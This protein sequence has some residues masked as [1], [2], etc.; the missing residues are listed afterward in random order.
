MTM[1]RK[2]IGTTKMINQT[3][4]NTTNIIDFI[5]KSLNTE[6]I[7]LGGSRRFGWDT[8][9]S[10]YDL[11][12]YTSDID[13]TVMVLNILGFQLKVVFN[14][15]TESYEEAPFRT[16]ELGKI[17]ISVTGSLGAWSYLR[18]NHVLV[19]NYLISNPRIVDFII[20]W[21]AELGTYL[22]GTYLVGHGKYTYRTLLKMAKISEEAQE[23]QL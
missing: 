20:H 14:E 15:H 13:Q 18:T 19:E 21:R 5:T 1:H 17:H 16:F 12:V 7:F 8:P 3:P 22:V 6:E 9:Y 4:D 23:E 11:F 2:K 10:D